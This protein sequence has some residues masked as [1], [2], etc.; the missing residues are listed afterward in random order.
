[1]EQMNELV[2][3]VMESADEHGLWAPHDTIV[4][5]VSGGP[6]SVALL[7]ILHEI[8][9]NRIPLN[10]VCAHVNHGFRAESVEEAEFVRQ[11]AGELG[12]PLS[13]P[14]LISLPSP[15]AAGLAPRGRHARNA[16]SF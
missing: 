8:S 16:I 12:V 1:M 7:R 5:A 2:E 4:V 9:V 10:L 6:D 13:W 14:N 3:S 15:K 11:M